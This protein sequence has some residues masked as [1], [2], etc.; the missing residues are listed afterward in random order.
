M[1]FPT[2]RSRDLPRKRPRLNWVYDDARQEFKTPS[3]RVISLEE[4]A[5]AVCDFQLCRVNLSGPWNGWKIRGDRLT[6]PG[7][8]AALKPGTTQQFLRWINGEADQ[9]KYPD[10]ESAG[11]STLTE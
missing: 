11:L 6:P 4:I 9:R 2:T 1:D 8:K 5:Q 10:N 7:T 3:G